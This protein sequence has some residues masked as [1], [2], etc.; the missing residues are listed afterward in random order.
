M[1]PVLPV[2]GP[3]PAAPQSPVEIAPQATGLQGAEL[4]S[5]EAGSFRDL[6]R[7]SLG[8][9]AP[10]EIEP[11]AG[12]EDAAAEAAAASLMP[13]LVIA[14]AAPAF[15]W[16]VVEAAPD[17]GMPAAQTAPVAGDGTVA[18]SMPFDAAVPESAAPA[19]EGDDSIPGAPVVDEAAGEPSEPATAP[20]ARAAVPVEAPRGLDVEMPQAWRG[21]AAPSAVARPGT[22]APAP[23][24]GEGAEPVDAPP[25]LEQAP[26][27]ARG[28]ARGFDLGAS[29][30]RGEDPGAAAQV[31][32][33][34][35]PA[36]HV[37]AALAAVRN[38]GAVADGEPAAASASP[39]LDL[40]RPGQDAAVAM[41]HAA[42]LPAGDVAPVRESRG[43]GA[44]A[45]SMIAAQERVA[46]EMAALVRAGGGH[47]EIE[48]SPPEL[49]RLRLRL[50]VRNRVVEGSI[51]VENAAVKQV[52]ENSMDRL[53][54]SLERQG[55]TFERLDV[56]LQDSHRGHGRDE[57]PAQPPKRETRDDDGGQAGPRNGN[58]EPGP[59]GTGSGLVDYWL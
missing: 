51:E 9:G 35:A 30:D 14:P 3:A 27:G 2:W 8:G 32:R 7:R 56:R 4:E 46:A 50:A 16:T 29:P 28:S 12:V 49:G 24:E 55:L 23:G 47:A 10:A 53:Q 45:P 26:R 57:E 40:L 42:R 18:S 6:V 15:E 59:R 36:A 19:P 44:H 13:P 1:P 54:V 39:V 31:R 11:D 34:A 5:A 37:P 33:A 25:P 52:L 41:Q 21:A 48:L 38:G 17:P 22:P 58:R 43:P 20:S